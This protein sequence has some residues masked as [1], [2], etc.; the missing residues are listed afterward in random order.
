[1]N[2]YLKYGVFILICFLFNTTGIN[3]QSENSDPNKFVLSSGLHYVFFEYGRLHGISW[4]VTL[5]YKI[6]RRKDY[7]IG[8]GFR[9]SYGES[10]WNYEGRDD[11]LYNLDINR[12][13]PPYNFYGGS[14]FP[15]DYIYSFEMDGKTGHGFNFF[16]TSHIGKIW[17]IGGHQIKGE[18]GFYFLNSNTSFVAGTIENTVIDPFWPEVEGEFTTDFLFPVWVRYLDI[19]PFISLKYGI[20]NHWKTPFG[21][22]VSYYHGFHKNSTFNAGCYFD[23][24]F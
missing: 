19:G 24:G 1:M 2:N 11:R 8:L 7:S 17:E 6:G 22:S 16:L 13:V 21:L 5:D 10:N 12:E 15:E 18:L 4:P 20:F 23:L 14:T 3:A 9:F